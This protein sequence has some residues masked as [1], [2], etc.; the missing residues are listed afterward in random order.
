MPS[1]TDDLVGERGV[2]PPA[3][4]HQVLLGGLLHTRHGG[5]LLEGRTG[6][7]PILPRPARH[8][9]RRP[10]GRSRPAG[11]AT[12]PGRGCAAV[13]PL[14]ARA[15]GGTSRRTTVPPAVPAPSPISTGATNVLL[16]PVRAC[17][18]TLV[19]CFVD[20][21]VVGEDRA[22]A[23]VGALA[24]L[25]VADVG[26]VRHLGAVADLG[27]LGL[28]ERADL[29]AGA[30]LG[31]GPQVGERPDGRALADH[32][33]LAVGADDARARADLAVLQR[34]VRPDHRVLRD[35]RGA[36]QLDARAGS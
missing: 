3:E 19:R 10:P 28:D 23:D 24:D 16:D 20:A 6:V 12:Q 9:P 30:Q 26:E 29:A 1:R 22:R 34:R 2:R 13:P 14:T 25:G 4:D 7:S 33:E 32:G 18:P 36:E 8:S 31:P 11:D 27:V 15:P 35:D 21:V 17:R 5:A